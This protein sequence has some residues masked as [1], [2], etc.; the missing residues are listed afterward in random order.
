MTHW[1]PGSF[2]E[3]TAFDQHILGRPKI[4]RVRA[5]FIGD[6][7]T[8]LAK[9]LAGEVHV[10]ASGTFITIDQSRELKNRWDQVDGGTVALYGNLWR[11]APLP[12]LLGG[13]T[14]PAAPAPLLGRKPAPPP[15]KTA[16][17]ESIT[18]ARPTRTARTL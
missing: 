3:G 6:A 17:D 13:P 5:E 11:A 18:G 15:H 1:E 2:V 14:Q 9:T 12:P 10:V 4:D 16:K 8:A 7:N